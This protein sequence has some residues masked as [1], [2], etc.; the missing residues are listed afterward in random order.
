[1]SFGYGNEEN[2]GDYI[3]YDLKNPTVAP[4]TVKGIRKQICQLLQCQPQDLIEWKVDFETGVI[5]CESFWKGR[6]KCMIRQ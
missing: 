2:A 3:A 1:M 6:I 5:L 4:N